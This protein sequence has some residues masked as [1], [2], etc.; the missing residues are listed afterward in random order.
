MTTAYL[1]KQMTYSAAM[2]TNTAPE[3]IG[4]ARDTLVKAL[5]L[6]RVK[7]MLETEPDTIVSQLE[8]IR[9]AISEASNFRILVIANIEK[10]KK[11]V[12]SWKALTSKGFEK[13]APL[14][15]RLARLSKAGKQPGNL[16]Y[17][18]PLAIDSSFALAVGKG[19]ES[20]QDP[21][22][23]ALMVA[24]AYLDAVEGPMWTAVRGTGL[25]YGTGFSRSI[26]SGHVIYSIYRSPDVSKAF[27]ASKDVLQRF[28]S[29]S[30]SFDPLALEG[31]ISSIVFDFANSQATMAAAAQES[32]VRQVIRA[33]PSDWNDHTLKRVRN[34]TVDEVR[35]A[36][37]DILLPLLTPASTNLFVTCAAVMQEVYQ[38][39]PFEIWYADQIQ[40]L[41]K[42]FEGMGFRPEVKPLTFFQ[43]DYGLMAGDEEE[44][45]D[46][47]DDDDN[48]EDIDGEDD[49]TEDSEDEEMSNGSGKQV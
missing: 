39:I 13:I 32:F 28:I 46:D 19:P 42:G 37:E 29:G 2:M 8:E 24:T 20:L 21:R 18:T 44:G 49:D 4:R 45:K 27:A 36:M 15:R 16:A 38:H 7:R 33:L 3:S 12:S 41:V 31:A 10:L 47:D 40:N 48:D 30:T 11:P 43:D 22:V 5:Y 17:I 34:V 26:D 35:K 6:K 14:D 1:I 25:A 9:R 23:H